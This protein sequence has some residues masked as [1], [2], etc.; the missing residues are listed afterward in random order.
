[1]KIND[2]KPNIGVMRLWIASIIIFFIF[3]F[4]DSFD[5]AIFFSFNVLFNFF[6]NF[7]WSIVDL[8][9]IFPEDDWKNRGDGWLLVR[10]LIVSVSATITYVIT[11][12]LAYLLVIW[13]KEGFSNTKDKK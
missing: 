4:D 7:F 13:V 10:D 6:I 12:A 9:N 8:T 1:L 2:L 11:T 5:S 3:T